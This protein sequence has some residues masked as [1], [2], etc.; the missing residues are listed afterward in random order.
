MKINRN[1]FL[2]ELKLLK[3]A[4]DPKGS[5]VGSD[6][7][8]IKDDRLHTYSEDMVCVVNRP[9][10]IDLCC[11]DVGR[12][13]NLVRSMPEELEMVME[14]DDELLLK[15][16]NFG[17]ISLLSNKSHKR[18]KI[19]KP[20]D[21]HTITTESVVNG[22][23]VALT[24]C[25]TD[26]DMPSLRGIR[27]SSDHIDGT[28]GYSWSRAYLD[29]P[30]VVEPFSLSRSSA[31]LVA[32]LAPTHVVIGDEW[33]H[34]KRDHIHIATY[35]FASKF[36]KDLPVFQS[37][38]K[39]GDISFVLPDLKKLVNLGSVLTNDHSN[40]WVSFRL[41]KNN[42]GVSWAGISGGYNVFYD[43]EGSGG[44]AN[45]SVHYSQLKSV[46]CKSGAVCDVFP[47][48]NCVRLSLGSAVFVCGIQTESSK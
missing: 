35:K 14:T 31:N 9:T 27:V 15:A 3:M 13:F 1:E 33:I 16:D 47:T 46:F 20:V 37:D 30:H 26:V 12:L 25:G 44:C 19:K 22:I 41:E 6:C 34:W 29:L 17:Q 42:L 39:S 38:I 40:P 8:A 43:V 21:W 5:V 23:E 11:V 2:D 24:S 36:P 4:C 10:N 18:P 7:V 48:L 32:A 45:F 28:N